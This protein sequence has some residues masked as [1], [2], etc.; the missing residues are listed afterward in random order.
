LEAAPIPR[1]ARKHLSVSSQ[2]FL[3]E[4]RAA[5]TSDDTATEDR[6]ETAPGIGGEHDSSSKTE[7]ERGGEETVPA[8]SKL[9]EGVAE[10]GAEKASSL[11]GRNDCEEGDTAMR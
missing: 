11:V 5:L 10:K 7:D 1:P 8:S 3:D 4:K 9:A 2:S 6:T